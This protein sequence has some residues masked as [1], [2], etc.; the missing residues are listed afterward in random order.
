MLHL[1]IKEF[2][3]NVCE[4]IKYKP[5]RNEISE[6]LKNHIEEH[7]ETYM[8]EGLHEKEAEE[9]AIKQMG[10]AEEIGKR[11]NKI[12]RPKLDWKLLIVEIT[13]LCFSFL[14]V[15]TRQK[16]C[17]N[18]G[19]PIPKYIISLIL[20][21]ICS[22]LIYFMDYRKIC[23]YSNVL[24]IIATLIIILALKFGI[25]VNGIYHL[26]L[27]I[28]T[29][30]PA[31][32]AMPLYIMAFIGFLQNINKESIVQ[33]KYINNRT[34][35]IVKTIILSLIS[36]IMF[37]TIPSITSAFIVGMVYLIIA[38]A[39]ILQSQEKRTRYLISLW[40]VI[41]ILEAF[42]VTSYVSV[43]PYNWERL[44]TSFRPEEDPAGSGWVGVN[45][46]QIIQSANLFGEANNTS[47]ALE[48]F[49][50]GTHFAFIS[51]LAHYGWGISIGMVVA[52]I[53]LCIKLMINS[54][55]IKDVYGKLLTIG[56]S[57]LFILQSIFNL[58][59]NLNMGIKAS[60]NIPLI[61]YSCAGLVT[62]MMCLAL[63][64]CVYRRKDILIESVN[65]D[66][67]I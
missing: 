8:L 38:T 17:S 54:I 13:L 3:E 4:Q 6:E 10:N 19:N 40:G 58:L 64:F 50:E 59:M 24:Y 2:L 7:K 35:N 11:L 30:S 37:T 34:L 44:R 28:I 20:G 47:D 63:V 55:T 33:I 36:L 25:M 12:H 60:F 14:V 22:S 9:K 43:Q 23:K 18:I 16:N 56:I 65:S 26:D 61:S 41:L 21:V 52:I 5:I 57:S 42:V 32:I 48:L 62:N 53:L 27:R 66:C 51:I 15:I 29:V 49:D 31:V 45:Q 39:K 67:T 1:Q 46:K